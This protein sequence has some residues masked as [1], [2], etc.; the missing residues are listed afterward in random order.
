LKHKWKLLFALS[1]AAFVTFNASIG[2]PVASELG[3]DSRNSG[4]TIV[5][6]RS[7]GLH[8]T[9]I[10]LNILTAEN[11]AP[12]DVFRATFQAAQALK[13]RRFGQVRLVRGL[14]HIYSMR[15]EDFQEIGREYE[16]GQN[17]VYLIRTFPEKLFLPNGTSAFGTWTGGLLGVAMQQMEDVNEAARAWLGVE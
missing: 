12:A 13:D 17:P 6:Y 9:D 16:A 2:I 15:G 11:V 8:P 14:S 1:L 3:R 5:A 7:F 4:L 10:T